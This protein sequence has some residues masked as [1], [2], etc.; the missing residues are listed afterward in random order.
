MMKDF[1]GCC[2]ETWPVVAFIQYSI[3]SMRE[4]RAVC[5]SLVKTSSK[6]RGARQKVVDKEE[7]AARLDG[8]CSKAGR[9]RLL[10]FTK[11]GSAHGGQG[12]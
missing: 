10:A 9:S 3:S 8:R 11:Y 2:I 4:R 1:G 12:M 7:W 6:S 5:K